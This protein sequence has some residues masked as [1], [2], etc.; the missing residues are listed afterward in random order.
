MCARFAGRCRCCKQEGAIKYNNN[1]NNNNN[2]DNNNNNN[3]LV[4]ALRIEKLS[5]EDCKAIAGDN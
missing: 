3:S 2:N 1:N 4:L 5:Q